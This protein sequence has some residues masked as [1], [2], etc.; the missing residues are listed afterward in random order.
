M[1]KVKRLFWDLEVSPGLY[2]AWRP[3]YN[4]HLSY[5]NQLQEAAI[6]CA[7]WKWEDSDKVHHLEWDKNQ[8]DKKLIEKLVK[9]L[10][11]A[12]EVCG[13]NSD[14]FDTKWLRTRAIKHG[15]PMSPEFVSYDTYKEAKK[16]FRFDSSSLDYITKYLGVRQKQDTGGHKLWVEV[17]F[18]K[19]KKALKR[20]V[21]YCDDDVR[22]QADVFA[23][24]KPYLKSQANYAGYISDCPE[25][26]GENVTI[27]K[28][29]KTAQGHAKIQFVCADCGRYHTVAASRFD[30]D[31]RI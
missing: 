7:S 5:K 4:I 17:V 12:D 18:N 6:I 26:G 9:V 27:S 19:N 10:E 15:V 24:M 25:C 20:M 13:H 31:A 2:W 22:A 23:K 16:L 1:R 14:A 29:R 11:S 21:S 8:C 28:R 3:G 30:K